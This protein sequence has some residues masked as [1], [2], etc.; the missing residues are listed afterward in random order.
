MSK[1]QILT[2]I[3]IVLL[4]PAAAGAAGSKVVDR[5]PDGTP[6]ILKGDLGTLGATRGKSDFALNEAARNALYNI[7]TRDFGATGVEEMVPT[8]VITDKAGG[9]HVRF[10]QTL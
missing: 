1:H 5:G 2:A 10:T 3:L 6:R 9:V 8:R 7:V 4:L